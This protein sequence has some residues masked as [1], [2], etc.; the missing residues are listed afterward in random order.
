[1]KE[2]QSVSTFLSM[3]AL[4]QTTKVIVKLLVC[5]AS[6]TLAVS[7]KWVSYRKVITS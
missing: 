5:V 6:E 1:M 2:E 3:N 4:V 7:W